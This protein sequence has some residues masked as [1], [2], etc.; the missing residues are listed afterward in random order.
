M[1]TRTL[2]PLTAALVAL[3]L[4][5]VTTAA[6]GHGN[7]SVPAVSSGV[8]TASGA[9]GMAEMPGMEGMSGMDSGAAQERQHS[10]RG[11]E[12]AGALKSHAI[13]L[14]SFAGVNALVLI[15]AFALRRRDRRRRLHAE[16]G[17]V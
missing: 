10:S 16:R 1:Q 11:T 7:H 12:A 9:R 13:V 8:T 17:A 5:P 4:V 3:A 6:T 2:I 15:S 14:S